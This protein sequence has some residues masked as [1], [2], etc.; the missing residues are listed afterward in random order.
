MGSHVSW[1]VLVIVTALP[2]FITCLLNWGLTKIAPPSAILWG[3]LTVYMVGIVLICVA[4]VIRTRIER[5]RAD[6]LRRAD[7]DADRA[8]EGFAG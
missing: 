4:A 6:R 2:V 7:A 3:L 8:G 5:A 1:K